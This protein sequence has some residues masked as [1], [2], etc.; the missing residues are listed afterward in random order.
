MREK[1]VNSV[2]WLKREASRPKN[3]GQ[4]IDGSVTYGKH[5]GLNAIHSPTNQIPNGN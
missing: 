2:C 1:N 5:W 3:Q 4:K